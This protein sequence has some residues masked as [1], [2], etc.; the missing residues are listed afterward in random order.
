MR[1][2]RATIPPVPATRA[3][4]GHAG[5][6]AEAIAQ[7][8]PMLAQ[9]RKIS[10]MFGPAAPVVQRAKLNI[11][12]PSSG[13]PG[14]ISGISD[15]IHRPPSN[16]GKQGQH[17]TAYVT[18]EQTMLSRVRDLTPT[19]AAAELRVVILEFRQ[20]PAMQNVTQWNKHIHLSLDLID[21]ALDDATTMSEKDAAK[22][23]GAQIDG[24]LRERNR[25]P[26]TAISEYGT[27]GH[28]E[29]KHAGALETMETA[30]RSGTAGGYGNNEKAQAVH[31]MWALLDY[32]PPDP[33]GQDQLDAISARILTHFKSMRTAFPRVFNW[34]SGDANY[35]LLPYLRANRHITTTLQRVSGA[36]LLL[37]ENAVHGAL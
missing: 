3:A 23:V 9:R 19:Q 26:G 17:L 11:R 34:L 7:S 27:T 6:A 37:V 33:A 14:T 22:V 32:D 24:L 16:L 4:P 18:F 35:W 15:W 5:T 29:A 30:L 1:Q 36:N 12:G 20:L 8:P 21:S 28:G 10:A 13:N 31:D 25:V 2:S